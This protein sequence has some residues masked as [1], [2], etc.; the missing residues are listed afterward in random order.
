MC[1]RIATAQVRE[2][3]LLILIGTM[4]DLQPLFYLFLYSAFAALYLLNLLGFHLILIC[5]NQTTNEKLTAT[6]GSRNPF[7]LGAWKNWKGFWLIPK[8]PSEMYKMIALLTTDADD[9]FDGFQDAHQPILIGNP[10]DCDIP[11]DAEV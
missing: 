3:S 4:H 2:A 6:Y 8:D 11:S 9:S 1:L 5:S 10:V 7:T